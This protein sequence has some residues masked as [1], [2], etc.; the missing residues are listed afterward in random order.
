MINPYTLKLSIYLR[1]YFMCCGEGPD[2]KVRCLGERM[3]GCGAQ[4]PEGHR[5]HDPRLVELIE[6]LDDVI[7]NDRATDKKTKRLI[8]WPAS[9]ARDPR[10]DSIPKAL[11]VPEYYLRA[12]ICDLPS[13]TPHYGHLCRNLPCDPLFPIPHRDP[14][15]GLLCGLLSRTLRHD[16][17]HRGARALLRRTRI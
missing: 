2:E 4:D 8:A 10:P 5:A 16:L 1:K 17:F 11:P 14:P 15:C 3:G 9:A 7:P 13:R 12:L 6:R